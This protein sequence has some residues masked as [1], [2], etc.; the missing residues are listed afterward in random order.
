M[1]MELTK[2]E[3]KSCAAQLMVITETRR[4]TRARRKRGEG[5]K[6]QLR[7][8]RILSILIINTDKYKYVKWIMKGY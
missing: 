2:L 3:F 5:E 6:G 7:T 4:Y 1:N 8:R